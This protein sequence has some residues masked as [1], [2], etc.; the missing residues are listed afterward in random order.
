MRRLIDSPIPLLAHTTTYPANVP[1][2]RLDL[3]FLLQSPNIASTPMP[4]PMPSR[5]CY[6]GSGKWASLNPMPHPS[7]HTVSL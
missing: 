4:W 3:Y 5:W 2:Y 1:R 7:S 6:S